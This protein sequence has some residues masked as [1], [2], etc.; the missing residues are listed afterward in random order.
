[1]RLHDTD[2][3]IPV[4]NN[5]TVKKNFKQPKESSTQSSYLFFKRNTKFLLA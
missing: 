4:T 2:I 5:N 3:I 1:M